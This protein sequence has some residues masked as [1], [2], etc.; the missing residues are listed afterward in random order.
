MTGME[1]KMANGDKPPSSNVKVTIE[2]FQG[3]SI[4]AKGIFTIPCHND[5]KADETVEAVSNF[6]QKLIDNYHDGD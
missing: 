4:A 3:D 6:C 5:K 1:I 2:E